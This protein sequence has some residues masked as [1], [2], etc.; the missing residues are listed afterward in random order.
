MDMT[1]SLIASKF[2]SLER[3]GDKTGL[4]HCPAPSDLSASA[5][6]ASVEPLVGAVCPPRDMCP[7]WQLLRAAYYTSSSG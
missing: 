2:I 4:F 6:A 7:T 5:A 3:K 1:Q